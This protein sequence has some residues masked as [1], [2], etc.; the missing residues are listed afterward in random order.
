MTRTDP[1]PSPAPRARIRRLQLT[2]FRS[3]RRADLHAGD[4]PVLLLG[5]NGAGKTNLLEAISFLSPGRGLRRAMLEDVANTDGD[6]SWA[7]A[8]EV[9][10]ALGLAQ[11]GTGIDAPAVDAS[12]ARRCRIDREPVPSATA[13]AD[14]LR[15]IWLV[16]EMDG[17]FLG[18]AAERRRFLD[19][20]VLAIDATHGSRVNALERAL[21]SR[22]RLLEE[23]APDPRWLDAIE[24]EV[25]ELA[26]AV[27]AARTEAVSRL[28]REIESSRDA[29]SAFPTASL[30]LEGWLEADVATRPAI[31]IEDRYRASLREARPRDRAAGR[32]LEGPHLSDLVVTHAEKGIRAERASTGERKALLVGVVLS[33]ARLVAAMHGYA[34]V[35]LLDDVAAFLDEDRR[36][37]LFAALARLGAQVWIT[38]VDASAFAALAGSGE[39]FRVSPGRVEPA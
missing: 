6:G 34:P 11:L 16:P 32:T 13:F 15:V 28:M 25:A 17:L 8:A 5:P 36:A 35:V 20:L 27:A 33:H 21:R 38:G 37:A 9:E 14:H 19:R 24:H 29:A 3:Y 1:S 30:S 2:N 12:P 39:R 31:E 18:P 23:P 10:G 26:V 4:G 7:V 22:N